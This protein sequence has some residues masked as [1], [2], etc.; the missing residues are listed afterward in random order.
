MFDLLMYEPVLLY[1]IKVTVMLPQGG[2]LT[3]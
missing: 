3:V 2:M 1:R